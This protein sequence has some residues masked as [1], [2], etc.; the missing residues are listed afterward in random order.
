MKT[1]IR[2]A[3]ATFALTL[4]SAAMAQNSNSAYFLE[5]NTMR[6]QMNPAFAG[7]HNYVSIPILGNFNVNMRGNFGLENVLF[8][9]SAGKT[10]TFLSPE[11]AWSDVEKGLNP[12][13][14]IQED[15]NIQILGAGFRGM[16]G[17][18]TIG[19]N[20]RE[21][22]GMSLPFEIFDLMKNLSN[23]DYK[24]GDLN[25][26]ALGWAEL[27]LGHSHKIDNWSFGGKLKFLFGAGRIDANLKNLQLQLNQSAHNNTWMATAEAEVQAHVKGLKWKKE[28]K[29]YNV[30]TPGHQNYET[31]TGIDIDGSGLGGFGLGVDLGMEY[32]FKD[33][34]EG[35]K[36]SFA[37]LDLGFISWN[38][39]AV[40]V[41]NGTPFYFNG[42]S[43]ISV[44]GGD[45]EKMS[46]QTDRMMDDLTD[47]YH[48]KE[49]TGGGSSTTGI[50]ATMNIGVE[51]ALPAYQPLRFGL[52]SSTRFMGEYTW[53]EERISANI[54]PLKWL[55][56]NINLGLG[57]FGADFG[58]QVNIHPRGFNFF[59]GMDHTFGKMAKQMIPLS[60]KAQFSI[61]MSATW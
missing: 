40:A 43:N 44:Q 53:N 38:T 27:A 25:I 33:M 55:E 23:R 19:I 56:G 8:Q 57:T 22:S 13:N 60:S 12:N 41:N 30:Q 10:T 52:L 39:T 37:L 51:Y 48:L 24:V 35:L 1:N 34:V 32:D 31:I 11:V 6:H 50:G 46:D 54:S 15:L 26:E 2:I 17:Y 49:Q 9:N 45:G 42:F 58:W 21:F 7:E 28:T 14:K 18:N 4:S 59:V 29:D 3:L 16:G 5:G 47:L 36:A 61:G 20:L